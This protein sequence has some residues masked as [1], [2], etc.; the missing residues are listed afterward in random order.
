MLIIR[1]FFLLV[2]VLGVRQVF[3]KADST[4]SPNYFA[5]GQLLDLVLNYHPVAK[6]AALLPQEA[7]AELM[8]AKG[9][10]D[11]VLDIHWNQK[12]LF[13]KDQNWIPA[14]YYRNWNNFLK[15]PTYFADIKIGFEQYL[16]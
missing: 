3:C 6:Q 11:P 1:L 5:L 14:T 15:I 8:I 7:Q 10:F 4:S 9:A 12:R 16:G 2:C 13:N